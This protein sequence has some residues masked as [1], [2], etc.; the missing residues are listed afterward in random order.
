MW[1]ELEAKQLA[2][3]KYGPNIRKS[4]I[5]KLKGYRQSI[6]LMFSSQKP[7]PIKTIKS[8]Q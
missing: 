4:H 2:T 6:Y 1:P 5:D 7:V 8:I 3:K